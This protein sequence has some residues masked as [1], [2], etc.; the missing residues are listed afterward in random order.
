MTPFGDSDLF[1]LDESGIR[2][3]RARDASNAAA[4]ADIGVPIDTIIT[5]K[6]RTLTEADRQNI[7]G[8]IEPR[9]GRFWLVAL[10]TIYVFSF[11]PGAKV[12]AWSTYSPGFSISDACVFRR[13]VYVRSGDTIYCYGGL[14]TEVVYDDTVA[15]AWLPYFD[16]NKPT[17]KKIVTGLDIA[18]RGDWDAYLAP[19]PL[20]ETLEERVG[21]LTDT[22]FNDGT[23]PARGTATHMSLRFRSSGDGPAVLGSGVLHYE[24]HDA[25]D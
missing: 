24:L 21:L 18:A 17:Q 5:E 23:V 15:E 19:D 1:Y 4:T 7:T 8:L 12:S 6:L 2:S 20:D 13:R 22:T 3:L 9:N 11:F 25:E 10:D 14:G 16:A